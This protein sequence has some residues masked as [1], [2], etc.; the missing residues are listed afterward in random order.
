[1][2]LEN[3]LSEWRSEAHKPTY[4]FFRH[5]VD[6]IFLNFLELEVKMVQF[7]DELPNQIVEKS[8]S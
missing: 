1:M 2:F 3:V 7:L 6:L 4:Q 8:Q 5:L